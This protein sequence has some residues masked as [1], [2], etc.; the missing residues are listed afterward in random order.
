MFSGGKA[1]YASVNPHELSSLLEKGYR[2]EK[3]ANEACSDQ[4][5]VTNLHNRLSITSFLGSP[6]V[7]IS[8]ARHGLGLHDSNRQTEM[9]QLT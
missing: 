7:F 2:M 8:T 6:L 3:P 5:Y 1:P 9:N 4:M